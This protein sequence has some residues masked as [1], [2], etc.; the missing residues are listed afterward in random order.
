MM[1]SGGGYAMVPM[2]CYPMLPSAMSGTPA[3][4]TAT[5]PSIN[6]RHCHILCCSMLEYS[7]WSLLKNLAFSCVCYFDIIF[8]ENTSIFRSGSIDSDWIWPFWLNVCRKYTTVSF[9]VFLCFI[10]LF[11]YFEGEAGKWIKKMKCQ[12]VWSENKRNQAVLP[13]VQSSGLQMNWG[14]LF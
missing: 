10:L 7:N 13:K 8:L 1:P 12:Y 11:F 6:V 9:L 3:Q 4:S 5:V 2:M 14:Q